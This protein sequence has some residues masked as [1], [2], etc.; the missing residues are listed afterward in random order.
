[1]SK[2]A[3]Y[4]LAEVHLRIAATKYLVP[5]VIATK[6]LQHPYPT[7]P[8]LLCV[9]SLSREDHVGAM[10]VKCEQYHAWGVPYC[11]IIDPEKQTAWQYHAG[12]DPEQLD[13]TGTLQA[14]ELRVW[15]ND[16]FA[17]IH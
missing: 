14:G 3:I 4:A 15:M 2:Q 12:S 1:L 5:D 17:E 6:T 16:L 11:W 13:R 7:D 10:L 8:V 9:E